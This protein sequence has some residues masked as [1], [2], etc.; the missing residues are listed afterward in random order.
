VN[1]WKRCAVLASIA[2]T[3]DAAFGLYICH[4]SIEATLSNDKPALHSLLRHQ[5]PQAMPDMG[6]H[7]VFAVSFCSEYLHAVFAVFA[8]SFCSEYLHAVFAVGPHE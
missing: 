8:V 2:T 4:L 3:Q 1:G 5:S 7:A 6:L